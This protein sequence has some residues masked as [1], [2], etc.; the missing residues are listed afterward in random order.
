[1]TQLADAADETADIDA[2]TEPADDI[3]EQTPE[4]RARIQGWRPKE[5]YNGPEDKWVS[6]EDFLKAGQERLPML[7]Q[8]NKRL[9]EVNRDLTKKLKQME[10]V[11]D[12]LKGFEQRAYE[13]ALSDLKVRHEEAIEA[14]DVKAGKQV[15]EEIQSLKNGAEAI[16]AEPDDK[17]DLEGARQK[18]NDWIEASDWYMAD[19]ER[20]AYADMLAER[21]GAPHEHADG[22]DG[23]LAEMEEKVARK[24]APK[25]PSMVNG[26][27]N[28]A[29]AKK[30]GG[31][32]DLTPDEKSMAQRMEDMKIMTRDE[33][34]KEILAAR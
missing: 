20:T 24:F 11:V 30:T 25:K 1:M 34:A 4:D 21:M 10:K 31:Y 26:G 2:G 29:P 15:L 17:P 32:A 6:A 12:T 28:R 14:G 3:Q 7:Q 8:H 23:W 33:Y 22:V 16:K 27:G 18:L 19:K 5:E 13:R 9:S